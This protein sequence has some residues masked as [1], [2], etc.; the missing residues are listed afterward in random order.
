MPD[1]IQAK[2]EELKEVSSKIMQIHDDLVPKHSKLVDLWNENDDDSHWQG[3]AADKHGT[4]SG[5]FH[6]G[7]YTLFE[8]LAGG[9]ERID[10]IIQILRTAEEEA[11]QRLKAKA[12]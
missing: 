1:T 9:S 8:A 11:G 4:E 3:E 10:K 6:Q 7:F 2:Y 5:P 12:S